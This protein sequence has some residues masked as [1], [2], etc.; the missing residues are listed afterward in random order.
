MNEQFYKDLLDNLY[1]GIY[2]VDKDRI[3]TYWNKGAERITGYTAEQVIGRACRDN[4]LNHVSDS[5][6]Q[7]CNA[8][9]PLSAAMEDG[10]HR[11]AEVFAHHRDG[12][13]IPVLVRASPLRG[14][15]G[16]IIG[17][18]ETF[19]NNE[20]LIETRRQARSLEQTVLLDPL[21]GVGNRRHLDGRLASSLREFQEAQT[22]FG[23]M[24]CDIDN[25]KS[26]NDTYGHAI[27]D[28][29][30]RMVAETLRANIRSTDTV[31]RWGGEEF[32][33]LVTSVNKKILTG[34]AEKLRVLVANSSLDIEGERLAVTISAGASLAQPE[35]TIESLVA[36]VDT[37]MYASKQAGK[38]RVTIG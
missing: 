15:N 23:L 31:G 26:F 32:V 11:E 18:V 33:V 3:I 30:L 14:A 17:A 10:K 36:R 28:R 5:G 2:F 21:T 29:A 24:F 12:H 1:D 9:C 7:L 16:E 38:N 25:F 22:P 37:L 20:K 4:L 27:G 6:L 13:R 35:D 34:I 19:S 8:L